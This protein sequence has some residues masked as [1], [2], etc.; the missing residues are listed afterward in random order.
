MLSNRPLL[1]AAAVFCTVVVAIPAGPAG[2]T[3]Y[4]MVEDANLLAQTRA[5]EG[6]VV[7]ARISS[8]EAAPV[9]GH[10]STDYTIEI[11]RLLAGS[12]PGT[13]LIVRV[14]G[15]VRP[16]GVGFRAYGAP[17]FSVGDRAVLFLVPRQ[18]GTFG[19][20]HVMLGAFHRVQVPTAPALAVRNL[21]EATEVP[22]AIGEPDPRRHQARDYDAFV[23]WLEDRAQGVERPADY[24]V[25][26]PLGGRLSEKF[27]LFEAGGLNLRWFE[28]DSGG[29]V[30]WR[31]HNNGQPGLGDGGVS[32]FR[33]ALNAWEGDPLTPIRLRYAGRAGA[34]G[35]L[36]D[37][38][39]VNVLL[40][41]DPN[42]EIDGTFNCGSG[43]TL[44]IGGPWFV[45]ADPGRFRGKDFARI[46]GA[47]IV[48]NDGIECRKNLSSCFAT[49]TEAIY[50]HELGHTLGLGHSCGDQSSP[51]CSGNPDLNDALMRA[52]S[53]PGCR[54]ADVR[55][56]DLRG[57]RALYMPPGA[58]SRGPAAPVALSAELDGGGA[59][60]RWEDRSTDEDGFRVY[61]A[62]GESSFEQVGQASTDIQ[63]FRDESIEPATSYRY[64][65]ASFNEDG[66][67]RSAEVGLVVPPIT[68][69][70]VALQET[71]G[72]EVRVG[73][74]IE[75]VATFT[76]PAQHAEWTFGDT[77]V[78]Y[79]D[80]RCS[81]D[82]FCRSH[83]FTT[84]GP[85]TVRVSLEGEFGQ[86]SE[87][88]MTVQV[89]DAPF[90]PVTKEASLQWTIFGVR[91][92][93]GTFESN[94]W[95]HNAGDEPAL[96][97]LTFYPRG[98]QPASEPRMLTVDPAE[99]VFLPNVLDTV[100]ALS[101]GQG[102]VGITFMG[103]GGEDPRVLTISRAF[104]SQANPAE[105][106]FGQ[107]VGGQGDDLWTSG[108]KVV[109]GIVDGDGFIATLLA[110]NVEDHDGTVRMTLTDRDGEPVGDPAVF[111]LSP[112]SMRFRQLVAL[113]PEAAE[114][115]GPFTA[116]FTSD[117]IRYLASSTLLEVGSEDQ[118]F[119]PAVE[120]VEA[121]E[122]VVPRVVRSPGQFG[123]FLTTA[124][125][126]L[127]NA[128]VPTDLTFRLLLRGKDNSDA[129]EV[130]R[131]VPANGLLFIDDLV[132]ELFD[133]E[134]GTGALEVSWDNAQ[135]VA[136][137]VV[138]MTL[139]E[140]PRGERFGML[141]DSRP[142]DDAGMATIDF[143]AEQ[144]DLFRSQY[145]V[146]NRHAGPTEL[147]LALRDGNGG[148]IAQRTL[149]LQAL[150]HLELNL[151][152]IFAG[153][154]EGKNWS[155]ST[156]VVDGGPVMTYLA[157][158][159]TSGDVFL[160]P[161]R[162]LR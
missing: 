42:G 10:P 139:S 50:G 21:S 116:R 45:T 53:H 33:R 29:A 93:T 142:E 5:R 15:G 151:R 117:G 80:T 43:G 27:T 84:P 24:F 152:T 140:N 81:A 133:R 59:A 57:A 14:I 154:G 36:D 108:E 72:L 125:S 88:E 143:G 18:D 147:R 54:G 69:V 61:R 34:R 107:F 60:L 153:T 130:T 7:D 37:F 68:P 3:S 97:E 155:V 104:V 137:R 52:Q 31:L 150:Q 79:N 158:I 12:A 74:P 58:G 128:S 138:A 4:V 101:A 55:A 32:A 118:I 13:T 126:V 91:G 83:V 148:M 8:V 6:A 115:E 64:R 82:T 63:V 70:T 46:V 16:D 120:P 95:L 92:N 90:D 89:T 141:V 22:P 20:L 134:T 25:E 38:D 106:S 87:D 113:F 44:A 146:V 98:N 67:T 109:T 159:N 132:D 149:V 78:G 40:P 28:F 39:G 157:N 35:G 41:D 94:V 17:R 23:E 56:D 66:E 129:T 30:A 102:S 162:T 112:K 49:Q 77:G 135:D 62:A 73:E 96:A 71:P 100:F 111:V 160:V 51:S 127:N 161:G 105:G 26:T 2:A 114:R 110:A 99:S 119:V 1:F 121:A 76:G 103:T 19:I 75:F 122:L 85:H 123:V 131:T 144:S 48:M 136:P 65:V 124:L 145:G 11:E 156:E 86:I 47:D 9:S